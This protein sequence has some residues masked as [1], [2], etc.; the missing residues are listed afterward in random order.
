MNIAIVTDS[1]ADIP[2]KLAEDLNIHVVP[3]ILMLDGQSFEDGK[4]FSREDFYER[5][6]EMNPLP[7]TGTPAAGTFEQLYQTLFSRGFQEII[8]IHVASSLSSIYSTAQMAAQAFEKRVHVIDSESLSMGFGWQVITA[9]EA[10]DQNLGSSD[11]IGQIKRTREKMRLFAMLDTLE[12]VHRSGRV[13]WARAR[14]GSLLRIK[15]FIEVREGQVFSLGQTRTRRKGVA[16]LR[17]LLLDQGLL[18]RLAILHT[19]AENDAID[20]LNSLESE[21]PKNPLIVNVTTIIGTHVGPNGLGFA[22]VIK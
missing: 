19:N 7:T 2:E 16:H 20:F 11:I 22:A 4:G 10:A 1:T 15:P 21:I 12:Y 3:A 8:S 18:E 17:D 9:A 14:I 6:P 13:G 5:L